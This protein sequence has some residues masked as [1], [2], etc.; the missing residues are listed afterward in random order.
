MRYDALALALPGD[1]IKIFPRGIGS[2]EVRVTKVKG[3]TVTLLSLYW[4]KKGPVFAVSQNR[5]S[6]L[7]VAGRAP[8]QCSPDHW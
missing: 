8:V 5:N 6:G 4:K 1:T 7:V 3:S 2:Q